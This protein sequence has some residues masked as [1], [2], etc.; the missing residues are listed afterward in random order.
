MWGLA[1]GRD[2]GRREGDPG[3]RGLGREMECDTWVA[4]L[5]ED[6]ARR[7]KGEEVVKGHGAEANVS[8]IHGRRVCGMGRHEGEQG[9]QA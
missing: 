7:D 5:S 6:S 8:R 4:A 2:G 9:G 1:A 3:L